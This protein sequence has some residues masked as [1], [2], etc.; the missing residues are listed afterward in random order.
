MP[1]DPPSVES[2]PV[3]SSSSGGGGGASLSPLASGIAA[4]STGARPA[5]QL[6][7]ETPYYYHA[8][9]RTAVAPIR[10]SGLLLSKSGGGGGL[11]TEADTKADSLGKIFFMATAKNAQVVAKSF[12]LANRTLAVLRVN[13]VGREHELRTEGAMGGYY[14]QVNIHPSRIQG[15]LEPDVSGNLVE[16]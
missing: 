10:A 5:V 4:A 13:L 12:G 16:V 11:S 9:K 7:Q 3:V 2:S 8:T 1:K 15:V 6:G 14:L